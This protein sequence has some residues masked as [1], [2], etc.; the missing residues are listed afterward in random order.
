MEEVAM[1]PGHDALVEDGNS[2]LIDINLWWIQA[3]QASTN[4]LIKYEICYYFSCLLNYYLIRL[5]LK[6]QQ[7]GNEL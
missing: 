7:G 1:L 2:G 5:L 3:A 4:P 6:S